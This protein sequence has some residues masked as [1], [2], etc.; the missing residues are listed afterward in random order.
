MASKI[1][2]FSGSIPP[3]ASSDSK[4]DSKEVKGSPASDSVDPNAIKAA[5]NE[6]KRLRDKLRHR[7]WLAGAASLFEDS[8]IFPADLLDPQDPANDPR[9][10]HLL[11]ALFG[12]EEMEKMLATAEQIQES[13]ENIA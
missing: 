7:P 13:E 5:L 8:T 4:L 2:N 3:S 11:C 10:L 9:Y 6:Y 12:L 1:S